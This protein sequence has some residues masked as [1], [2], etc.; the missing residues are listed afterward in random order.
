MSNKE[1]KQ[2]YKDTQISDNQ[3]C[4]MGATN[5]SSTCTGDSGGPYQFV[6]P[7]NKRAKYVQHGIISFR[8]VY[9]SNDV[10]VVFT[11]IA[12]YM[13]WILDNMRP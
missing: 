10:P 7:I 12:N 6:H 4:G 5:K 3:I 1:C 9:C 2:L 8:T 11:K 13:N